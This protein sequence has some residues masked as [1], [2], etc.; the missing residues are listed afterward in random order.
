MSDEDEE[1]NWNK[2]HPGFTITCDECGSDHVTVDSDVG[3][4]E[5]TG[6]W[7]GVYLRCNECRKSEEIYSNM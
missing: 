1:M 3:W 5:E 6:G 4:S 2:T 7:G